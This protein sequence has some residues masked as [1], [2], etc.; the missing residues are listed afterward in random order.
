MLNLILFREK[1]RAFYAR[2]GNVI[3]PVLHF[4]VALLALVLLN[5]GMGYER[6]LRAPIVVIL[7]SLISAF[8]PW[9]GICVLL[10]IFAVSA[11]FALITLAFLLVVALLYYGFS[12]RD[13]IILI[14][15]PVLFELKIPYVLPILVGLGGSAFSLIPLSGGIVLSYILNYVHN[16]AAPLT[17][18][19]SVDVAQ[20]YLQMLNGVL[21]DKTMLLYLLAFSLS[22]LVVW[23]VHRLS[24]NN[25]WD[26]GILAGIL[27]MLFVFFLGNF[28]YSVGVKIIPLLA[29][30]LL[31]GVLAEIYRFLVFH[32]DYSRTEYSQFEDDDYY[33]YVKAVPKITV[34]APEPKTQTINTP[35][36]P[37]K[38]ADE[39]E[40]KR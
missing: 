11:E 7:L 39:G 37:R 38:S 23:C 28:W 16:N 18:G 10:N 32:V 19:E 17:N 26:L 14:L 8:L 35:K 4:A 27:T 20:K 25:A 22:L 6:R 34:A 3:I 33:Y 40:T 13:S 9:G 12:P 1:L 31:S 29:G 2:H 15:T 21:L 24:V 36:R 30:L 5:N